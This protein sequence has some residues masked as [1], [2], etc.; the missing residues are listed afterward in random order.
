MPPARRPDVRLLPALRSPARL[1]GAGLCFALLALLLAACSNLPAEL[2]AQ[3]GGPRVP[4]QVSSLDWEQDMR[5][6]DEADALAPPAPDAVVFTGSSSIRLWDTL[7]ADFPGV[8]VINRGF[9]GSEIRDSTWHAGRLVVRYAP[10]QVILYAGDN[11]L[12]SGRSPARIRAD[13]RAFVARIRQDL[14]DVPIAYLST[15]PSPARAHLLQA[16]R[17]ANALIGQDAGSLRVQFIDVFTP[18][19]DAS[20]Q[21]RPELFVED[22]LH[23]NQ[24]GYQLWRR[25][26]APHLLRRPAITN[27]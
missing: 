13:F 12:S 25:I 11:D 3:A 6:F 16:Q 22:G 20:G 14:P 1:Q 5:R 23:M 26:V 18:M 15:K 8:P 27:P 4:Q 10:R 7:A 2:S 21:P 9:G 19:L 17:K 24:A